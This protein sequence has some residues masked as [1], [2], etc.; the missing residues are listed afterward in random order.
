MT[1]LAVALA[2]QARPPRVFLWTG[3]LLLVGSWVPF[4]MA[5]Q[6]DPSGEYVGNAIGL[7]S[8]LGSGALSG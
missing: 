6:L 3:A 1:A 8:S 7:A 4:V 2:T 5:G